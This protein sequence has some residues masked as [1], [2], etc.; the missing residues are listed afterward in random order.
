LARR[1]RWD[2]NVRRSRVKAQGEM[3]AKCVR[4]IEPEFDATPLRLQFDRAIIQ[5]SGGRGEPE[6]G[7]I[8]REGHKQGAFEASLEAWALH[9]EKC[10]GK[11]RE[12]PSWR[13]ALRFGETSDDGGE[14]LG[15]VEVTVTLHLYN[16]PA[17]H[18][19]KASARPSNPRPF[20][21][22]V[23]VY[24]CEWSYSA[25]GSTSGAES[26]ANR[27]SC[28]Q[29]KT[30]EGQ[31]Y[32]ESL[33]LGTTAASEDEVLKILQALRRSWSTT[34][35]ER[36]GRT[37]VLFAEEFCQRLGVQP[38]PEWVLELPALEKKLER[39]GAICCH[40][41]W[42]QLVFCC[43]SDNGSG[44]GSKVAI[45]EDLCMP[46]AQSALPAGAQKAWKRWKSVENQLVA[47]AVS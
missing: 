18:S 32:T 21:C 40:Q 30:C 25:T 15:N 45:G 2:C 16:V 34:G 3:G 43:G 19:A 28:C 38:L 13:Q 4:A 5:N 20:H 46:L 26:P 31:A 11:R 39:Q 47:I 29:P 14:V 44:T 24:Q 33:P 35:T 12:K 1:G 9:G 41:D 36:Q 7:G 6:V 23:E 8:L 37:C 22:G 17:S 10:T 42:V 27:I